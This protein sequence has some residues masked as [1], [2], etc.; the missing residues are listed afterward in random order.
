MA[1]CSMS[2]SPVTYKYTVIK[3]KGHPGN[4]KTKVTFTIDMFWETTYF[5]YEA[6]VFP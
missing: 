1:F 6:T 4:F 3:I 2:I 5:I